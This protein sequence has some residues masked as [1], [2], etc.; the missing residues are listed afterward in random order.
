M[1]TALMATVLT[2]PLEMPILAREHMNNWY[3]LKAFYL[4]K[5]T[6][7]LPFQVFFTNLINNRIIY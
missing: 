1:F 2:F 5:S 4:A 7:D 3:T 6:A